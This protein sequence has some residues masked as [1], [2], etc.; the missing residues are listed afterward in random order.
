MLAHAIRSTSPATP[1]SRYRG[2][3]HFT[4]QLVVQPDGGHAASRI[5]VGVLLL[6]V[7]RDG[8]QLRPCALERDRW[9]QA[10][11]G[12]VGVPPTAGR[13]GPFGDPQVRQPGKLEAGRQHAD[14]RPGIVADSYGPFQDG[15]VAVETPLPIVVADERRAAA[16]QRFLRSE[17]APHD[18][19]DTE[20]AKEVGVHDGDARI[21]RDLARRHG[22][23]AAAVGGHRLEGRALVAPVAEVGDR[24]QALRLAAGEE[25]GVEGNDPVRVVVGQRSQQHGID[26]AEDGRVG[27]NAERHDER[28]EGGE[29]GVPPEGA[30]RVAEVRNQV[31][32]EPRGTHVATRLL[33]RLD[34]THGAVRSSARFLR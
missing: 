12:E 25:G 22:E 1:Q 33:A 21:L 34:G 20:H 8:R 14:D 16:G 27:P 18:R 10:A 31:P 24:D 19:L 28:G 26:N 3:A 15:G 5:G 6:Q 4:H 7:G 11:D 30:S 9:S 32:D 2:R 29:T 13:L 23:L 17:R